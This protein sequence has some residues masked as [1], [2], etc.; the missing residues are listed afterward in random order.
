VRE[1]I[2]VALVGMGGYG[3]VYLTELLERGASHGLRFVA[4]VD[5]EPQRSDLRDAVLKH[6]VRIYPSLQAFQ[7]ETKADLVVLS[8]PPQF[9]CEQAV[10]AL[11]HGSHV[12]CEKPAAASPAQIHQ[13]IAA[14]DRAKKLVAIGYQWSFSPAIQRLK[15]DIGSG[16]FGRPLRFK[17][18]A[19]WPRDERYYS[20]NS[21]AGRQRDA[22]GRLVLDSPV[23]NACAHYLHNMFYV[24]GEQLDRSAMPR[25]VV[26]ELYRANEIENYDTAAIRCQTSDD[27]ELLFIATHATKLNRG[28]IVRYE[29]ENALVSHSA[30]D[31]GAF[32]ARMKDGSTISYGTPIESDSAQ[33]LL[34]V[35]SAIRTGQAVACGLEAAAAH[36][37]CMF[38][39]QQ[40][41][42][43]ITEFPEEMIDIEGEAGSRKTSVAGLEAAL[44]QCF[45]EFRLPSEL[46]FSW[47]RPSK[48]IAVTEKFPAGPVSR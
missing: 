22:Q 44:D 15:Q 19:Y 6:G 12:L 16:R 18:C 48:P 25:S 29:F 36:T 42:P 2:S 46:G 45:D 3:Q 11:D 34:E 1:E 27:V 33:K 23:N 28:P 38:A 40:S 30:H 43:E 17:T 21:W 7:N 14:R 35:C 5:P 41:M 24:L 10:A 8:T 32:S 4:A 39:A 9:H 13:M 20:R 47:S 37:A 31:G 26:A